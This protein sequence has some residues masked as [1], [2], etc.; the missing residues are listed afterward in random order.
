MKFE[1]VTEKETVDFDA[2]Y[3]AAGEKTVSASKDKTVVFVAP[4]DTLMW[5]KKVE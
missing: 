1:A 3:I 4:L 2:D 5:V